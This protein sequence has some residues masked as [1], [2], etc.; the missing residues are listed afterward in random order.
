[1]PV[2]DV[3]TLTSENIVKFVMGEMGFVKGYQ[4][5]VSGSSAGEDLGKK[6]DVPGGDLGKK[7][8]E[9]EEEKKKATS[10]EDYKRAGQLKKEI[11]ELRSK[12]KSADEDLTRKLQVLEEEKK[13]AI[14]KED[15]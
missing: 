2:E 9:L 7:I 1:M 14:A 5:D 10:E 13:K 15:Y 4:A 12:S 3:E 11:E 6:A 8:E